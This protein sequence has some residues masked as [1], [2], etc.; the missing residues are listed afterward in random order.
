M[1][2][3]IK[4][5]HVAL[6]LLSISLFIIRAIWSTQQSALLQKR[7]VKIVP[8]IID[9]ML[10]AC[11]IFLM[12]S[13]QQYPF[14]SSWLTA[15][16]LAL[17]LYIGLGTIAIKRG[18]TPQVRLLA[19]SGAIIVFIYIVGVALNHSYWAWL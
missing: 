15:K 11:A 18:K 9:S 2:L 7:W 4:H 6:A 13:I 3:I 19:A 12:L 17:I 16:L 10:L 1:Y 8:H 14:Q 5:S